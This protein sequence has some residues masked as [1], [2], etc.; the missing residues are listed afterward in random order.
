MLMSKLKFKNSNVIIIK[1]YMF[2]S[3]NIIL[4]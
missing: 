1:Y 2:M 4:T 3:Y